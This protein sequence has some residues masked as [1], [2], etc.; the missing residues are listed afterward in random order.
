[1]IQSAVNS[2]TDSGY[3]W[4]DDSGSFVSD[5]TLGYGD[6]D[7]NMIV[8]TFIWSNRG[9]VSTNVTWAQKGQKSNSKTIETLAAECH[10]Q[11]SGVQ[12]NQEHCVTKA[13]KWLVGVSQADNAEPDQ[14]KQKRTWRAISKDDH[15]LA[16]SLRSTDRFPI[17]TSC[18]LVTHLTSTTSGYA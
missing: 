10:I 11:T 12:A 15:R 5:N 18:V 16:Q 1:M 14:K 4:H 2:M 8:P 17:P 3:G 6:E 9:D 13:K 7:H